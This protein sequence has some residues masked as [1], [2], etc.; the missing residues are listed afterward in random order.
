MERIL[1][2]IFIGIF[3]DWIGNFLLLKQLFKP[4]KPIKIGFIKIQGIV[5]KRIKEI[6]KAVIEIAEETLPWYLKLPVIREKV[7]S[8]IMENYKKRL[9]AEKMEKFIF[10]RSREIRLAEVRTLPITFI[11]AVII[12]YLLSFIW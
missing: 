6:H 8:D 2:P 12:A 4:V 5:P 10:G 11:L 3:L 9:T 7:V 1:I